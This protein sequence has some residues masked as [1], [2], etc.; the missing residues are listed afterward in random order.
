MT[1]T[2]TVLTKAVLSAVEHLG[3]TSDQLAVLLDLDL[4]I[5]HLDDC[6]F[7]SLQKEIALMLIRITVSLD[8][9]SG[10]D[11]S[12]TQHFMK[13]PNKATGGIPVEQIQKFQGLATVLQFVEGLQTKHSYV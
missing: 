10:G 12:M 7:S 4:T 5:T 6:K 2:E 3:L 13:S 8:A 11:T 9:L 1:K